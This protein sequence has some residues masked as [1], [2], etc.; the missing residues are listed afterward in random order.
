M[1]NYQ[2]S[3][4]AL[5]KHSKGI[6]YRFAN[7]V[8]E[9]TLEAYLAENPDKSEVDFQ[10]LKELSDSDYLERDRAEYNQTRKNVSIHAFEDSAGF[11]IVPLDEAYLDTLDKLEAVRAFKALLTE[12]ELTEAQERRF[13]MHFFGGLSHRKIAALEGVAVRAVTQSIHAASDKLRKY[14]N[15]F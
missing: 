7:E 6:V 1:K 13:W 5:N 11:G 4:Y 3:D 8:V 12:G 14:F 10:V 15:N 2:D 9:I